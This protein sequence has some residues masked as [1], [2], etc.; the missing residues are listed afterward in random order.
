LEEQFVRKGIPYRLIGG[1]RFYERREIKD[2]LAYMRLAANPNDHIS[3]RRIINTPPRGIGTV[4]QEKYLG[5]AL[6]SEKERARV[7]SFERIMTELENIYQSRPTTKLADAVIAKSG[8]EAYIRNGTPEGEDRW[9]NTQELLSVT[10]QH[11]TLPPPEGTNVFLEESALLSDADLVD[12]S[13]DAVHIMTIHAA[14]GLEFDTVFIAGLE[15]GIFPHS[16]SKEDPAQMEEERRLCY[17]A[18]TRAKTHLYV[19]T[20]QTRTLYG[21]VSWNEPSRFLGEIPQHLIKTHNIP[22]HEYEEDIV[23]YET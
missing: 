11:D 2:I 4:L 5:R 14:K 3:R 9:A 21:D 7:E 12:K 17:V 20:A 22:S 10:A 15:E 13:A 23:G 1:V 16:L 18:L 8:Y 19:S 6:L